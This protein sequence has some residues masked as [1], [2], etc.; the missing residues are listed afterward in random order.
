[1]KQFY[2]HDHDSFQIAINAIKN[3]W[4]AVRDDGVRYT[5]DIGAPGD[6]YSTEQ[7]NMCHAMFGE[8]AAVT[9]NTPEVVKNVIMSEAF[10]PEIVEFQGEM[11]EVRK[12]FTRLN[13]AQASFLIDF[14]ITFGAEQGVHLE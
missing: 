1:V 13:K 2:L 10:P 14:T 5:I 12:S 3:L 11:H 7:L 9:G 6:P 8:I 4:P